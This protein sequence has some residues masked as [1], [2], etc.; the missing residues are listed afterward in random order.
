MDLLLYYYFVKKDQKALEMVRTTLNRM[1]EGGMYDHV[2]KVV[3]FI[4]LCLLIT[5]FLF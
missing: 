4:V 3:T 5:D 1:F 2:G